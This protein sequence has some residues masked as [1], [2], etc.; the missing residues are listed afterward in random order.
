MI[1]DDLKDF[2]KKAIDDSSSKEFD[3]S[4]D[5][6]SELPVLDL[7]GIEEPILEPEP[8]GEIDI[9]E[10]LSGIDAPPTTGPFEPD[11]VMDGG[12]WGPLNPEDYKRFGFP[13]FQIENPDDY[14]LI[15]DTE[16]ST[17]QKQ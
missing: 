10:P 1:I 7:D 6:D 4:I 11:I 17:P 12:V 9:Y 14:D 5:S 15:P 2:A 16:S 8:S 13:E 3:M